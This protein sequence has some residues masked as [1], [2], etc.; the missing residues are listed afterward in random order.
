MSIIMQTQMEFLWTKPF[1]LP[2]VSFHFPDSSLKSLL[3][4]NPMPCS[5]SPFT[6]PGLLHT[7]QSQDEFIVDS[8]PTAILP[9]RLPSVHITLTS[10]WHYLFLA[11]SHTCTQFTYYDY[12]FT[13]SLIH[14]NVFICFYQL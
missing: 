12:C 6:I 2:S 14:S 8:F 10:V 11:A 9:G 4:L 7:T 13:Y 5:H 1:F 3:T